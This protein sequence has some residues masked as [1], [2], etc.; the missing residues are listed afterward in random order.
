MMTCTVARQQLVYAIIIR[1]KRSGTFYA[2]AQPLHKRTQ[3]LIHA[4]PYSALA[5]VKDGFNNNGHHT[6]RRGVKREA[7]ADFGCNG[8]PGLEAADN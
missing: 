1:H 4:R 8:E 5:Q 3:G 6:N 7:A 2:N